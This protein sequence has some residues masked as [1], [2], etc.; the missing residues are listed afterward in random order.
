MSH[1]RF[2]VAASLTLTT[3]ASSAAPVEGPHPHAPRTLSPTP[4]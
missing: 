2:S 1:I 4:W 3:L